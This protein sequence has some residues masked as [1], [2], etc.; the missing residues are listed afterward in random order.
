MPLTQIQIMPWLSRYKRTLITY[1]IA[2]PTSKLF[3][4]FKVITYWTLIWQRLN[5]LISWQFKVNWTVQLYAVSYRDLLNKIK[6]AINVVVVNAKKDQGLIWDF[7]INYLFSFYS[8]SFRI[9]MRL[10]LQDQVCTTSHAGAKLYMRKF[11]FQDC[12]PGSYNRPS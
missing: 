6:T 9:L 7:K 8:F 11:N 2:V 4:H 1:Y 5:D 3:S 10:S 12:Y